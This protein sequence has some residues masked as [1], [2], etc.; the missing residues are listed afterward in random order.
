MQKRYLHQQ[1][2]ANDGDSDFTDYDKAPII[3]V[4]TNVPLTYPQLFSSLELRIS[5]NAFII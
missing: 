2:D 4:Q 3:R 5:S 1:H